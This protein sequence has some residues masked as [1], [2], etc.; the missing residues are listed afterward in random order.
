MAFP[1]S[2]SGQSTMPVTVGR[3][4]DKSRMRISCEK[5]VKFQWHAYFFFIHSLFNF[6]LNVTANIHFILN[7]RLFYH[8]RTWLYAWIMVA[9]TYTHVQTRSVCVLSN[10]F[11]NGS[12]LKRYMLQIMF[13]S[14]QKYLKALYTISITNITVG[15]WDIHVYS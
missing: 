3:T 9:Q 10:L 4:S 14:V 12:T 1:T 6:V 8:G 7:L 11:E 15:Q 13:L 2:A 5:P